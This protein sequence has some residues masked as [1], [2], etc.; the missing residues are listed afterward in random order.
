M[1]PEFDM[2]GH[3]GAALLAYP[4]LNPH[5]SVPGP[6]L[7]FGV[8]SYVVDP[9]RELVYELIA[10][11]LEQAGSVFPDASFHIGGDEVLWGTTESAINAWMRHHHIS[12]LHQY[13]NERVF[14]LVERAGK[15][16]VGWQEIVRYEDSVIPDNATV[17]WWHN[18]NYNPKIPAGIESQG[19]YLDHL[20]DVTLYW[21]LSL[22]P[23]SIGGEACMWSEWVDAN[24]DTRIFPMVFAIGENMWLGSDAIKTMSI[25]NFYMRLN[26]VDFV[27]S[28]FEPL[29]R[30]TFRAAVRYLGTKWDYSAVVEQPEP[31]NWPNETYNA[32][33]LVLDSLEPEDRVNVGGAKIPLFGIEDAA[34]PN[35]GHLRSFSIACRHSAV[36]E[37][38]ENGQPATTIVKD[39]LQR[40]ASLDPTLLGTL[41]VAVRADMEHIVAD[42]SNLARLTLYWMDAVQSGSV[43]AEGLRKTALAAGALRFTLLPESGFGVGNGFKRTLD[44][45]FLSQRIVSLTAPPK[46]SLV[47]WSILLPLFLLIALVVLGVLF[48]VHRRQ[49]HDGLHDLQRGLVSMEIFDDEVQHLDNDLQ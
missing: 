7:S 45:S 48:T 11:L 9:S 4:E 16:V 43:D 36:T 49:R 37:A 17:Q 35:S 3:C 13:F 31:E 38:L 10:E 12:N 46:K 24:M 27:A 28:P 21:W 20:G 26:V 2:P 18:Y 34:K 1:Y 25:W 42:M 14:K 40:Y 5:I 33:Y 41:P 39:T 44:D 15:R 32:L 29:N 30:A 19:L 6:I 23:R 8:F 22:N 47:I